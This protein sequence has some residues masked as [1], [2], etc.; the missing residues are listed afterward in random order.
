[1]AAAPTDHSE[2]IELNARDNDG[3]T[4]F[5]LAGKNGHKDVGKLVLNHSGRFELNATNKHGETAFTLHTAVKSP[6]TRI[7]S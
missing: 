7:N 5:M 6:K 2:R 4:P 1:M 3:R